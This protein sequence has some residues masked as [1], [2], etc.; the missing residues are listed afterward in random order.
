MLDNF[1]KHQPP[2][3]SPITEGVSASR[4]QYNNTVNCTINR[5]ARSGLFSVEREIFIAVLL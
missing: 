3:Y 2:T 5:G 1:E 4:P